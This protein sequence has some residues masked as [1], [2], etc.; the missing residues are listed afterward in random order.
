MK[1]SRI[2]GLLALGVV[3]VNSNAVTFPLDYTTADKIAGNL[4]SAFYQVNNDK[5][6]WSEAGTAASLYSFTHGGDEDNGWWV[7]IAWDGNPQP[8]LTSAI[9]KASDWY[10]YWDSSDLTAFNGGTYDSVT[11]WQDGLSHLTGGPKPQTKYH[12]ISHAGINGTPGTPPVDPPGSVPDGGAT[13]A[14][15][16]LGFIAVEGLRRK[17][18]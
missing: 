16:G 3:A 4:T 7:K 2:L 5:G 6:V 15:L 17:L 11:L 18:S 8:V 10:L 14:L 12:E 13:L 1:T 9:M